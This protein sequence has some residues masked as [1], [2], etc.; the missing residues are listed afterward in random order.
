MES[1]LSSIQ[2]QKLTNKRSQ[3]PLYSRLKKNKQIMHEKKPSKTTILNT[4]FVVVLINSLTK[5]N[6]YSV[7]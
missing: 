1:P 5:D 4:T 2:G 7:I 3:L 6:S